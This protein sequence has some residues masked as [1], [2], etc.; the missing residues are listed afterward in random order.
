[1]IGVCGRVHVE[2]PAADDHPEVSPTREAG[3]RFPFQGVEAQS[4]SALSSVEPGGTAWS[5]LSATGA[6]GYCPMVAELSA[7]ER[8]RLP[9][10][11][12]AYIDSRGRRRLPINDEPHVRNALARFGQVLFE[13]DRAR[14][15]ARS[16][17]L[18]AAKRYGIVPVGFFDGQIRSERAQAALDTEPPRGE[19]Q[20]RSTDA[21]TLPTGL[22]TFLLSDMERS[23]ALVRRL[24]DRYGSLLNAV[25]RL[26]RTTVRQAGGR[27][28]DAH[29]DEF[30][31]VFERASQ[32][33]EAAVSLQR[34]MAARAWPEGL[35]C[36]V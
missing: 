33:V 27:E 4:R 23:T 36:R 16:R 30:F 10:R 13:D 1:M 21:A 14:E 19:V 31:A 9:D 35:E 29:A 5:D 20:A 24:G 25:R 2:N 34:E 26:I 15:R 8:A 12:F 22:L 7:R 17:L 3:D 28:V 11:A 18:N 6:T 32:A